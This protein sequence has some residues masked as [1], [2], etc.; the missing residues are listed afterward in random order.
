MHVLAMNSLVDYAS[1][2]C[3]CGRQNTLAKCWLTY[4][5]SEAREAMRTSVQ[6]KASGAI[7]WYSEATV[8][9]PPQVIQ[10]LCKL[11]HPR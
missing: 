10:S 6:T 2:E 1:T 5:S 3:N 7:E 4:T 11:L 8:T 9:Y